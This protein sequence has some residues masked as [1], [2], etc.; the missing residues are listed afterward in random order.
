[1]DKQR[2]DRWLWQARVFK[3]RG[4]ATRAVRAGHVQVNGHRAKPS[5]LLELSDMLEI[6]R[7]GYALELKVLGFP[8]RRGPNREAMLLYD[9]TMD[10]IRA[11]EDAIAR[12]KAGTA[13]SP[14]PDKRPDKRQRRSIR[15]SR[16]KEPH[17]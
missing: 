2:L 15:R 1:M 4:F 6:R 13:G 14:T 16:G 10:S 12:R 5:R 8:M 3:T 7:D 11:R 9:E 17:G